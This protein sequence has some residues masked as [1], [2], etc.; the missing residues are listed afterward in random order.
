MDVIIGVVL[1]LFITH[2]VYSQYCC[3]GD[4]CITY[5]L[6]CCVPQPSGYIQPPIQ[7]IQPSTEVVTLKMTCKKIDDFFC[8]VIGDDGDDVEMCKKKFCPNNIH[9]LE[10]WKECCELNRKTRQIV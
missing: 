7:Q 3:S 10:G 1:Q 4:C 2:G 9:N 8:P 6:L 5:P